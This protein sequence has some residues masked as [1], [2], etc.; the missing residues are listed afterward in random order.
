[1][2]YHSSFA[3]GDKI[4]K[5]FYVSGSTGDALALKIFLRN[6]SVR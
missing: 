3:G 5:E 4:P 6:A 2:V 1:M